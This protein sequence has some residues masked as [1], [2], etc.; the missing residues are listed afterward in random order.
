MWS[1]SRG[2]AGGAN[3]AEAVPDLVEPGWHDVLPAKEVRAQ[4]V[5]KAMVGEVPVVAI[6]DGG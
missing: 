6:A 5:A 3:Q 4:G 1:A 2:R